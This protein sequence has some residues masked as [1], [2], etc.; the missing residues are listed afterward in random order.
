M[1][2]ALQLFLVA[3]EV[4]AEGHC[5]PYYRQIT[6]SCALWAPTAEQAIQ[7][8]AIDLLHSGYRPLPGQARA[9]SCAPEGWAETLRL[10]WPA[11]SGLALPSAAQP[12]SVPTVVQ[13]GLYPHE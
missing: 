4:D 5:P 10:H 7:W 13:L 12:G 11:R 9:Q 2:P 3:I 1:E 6:V 8:A